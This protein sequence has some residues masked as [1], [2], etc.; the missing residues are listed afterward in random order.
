MSAISDL[1]DCDGNINIGMLS[2]ELG[3]AMAH[4]V[5]YKQ[6]DNMKKRAVKGAASYDEFKALVSCAHLQKISRKEVESLSDP[7]RGWKKTASAHKTNNGTILVPENESSSSCKLISTASS[8]KKKGPRN[9]SELQR[10]LN[11]L[12]NDSERWVYIHD[13]VTMEKTVQILQV[14]ADVDLIECLWRALLSSTDSEQEK[15]RLML[16]ESLVSL[17][18]FPLA[19][20]FAD[21]DLLQSLQSF[22]ATCGDD[23]SDSSD[24]LQRLRLAYGI[25]AAL[26][27]E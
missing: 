25:T 14:G 2:K 5:R 18:K 23:D 20:R 13:K 15:E 3:S 16:L 4:D 12:T 24:R 17:E 9:C 11:R 1:V 6:V 19:I 8:G 22:L 7:K 27:L 26:V 10:D 21:A